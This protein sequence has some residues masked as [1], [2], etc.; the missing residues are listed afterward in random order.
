MTDDYES[1]FAFNRWADRHVLDACRTLTPEQ[2]AAEPVP[3]WSSVRSSLVHNAIVIDGW[4][5]GLTGVVGGEPLTE[6]DLP[7][8]DDIERL[9]DRAGRTFEEL[10]PRFTP[11]WLSTPLTLRR[12][13]RS[14]ALPPWVVLRHVVNHSTYHRGQVAS[15]LKRF[16][17]EPPRIDFTL[18]AMEQMPQAG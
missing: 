12:G 16:G 3:G 14:V 2:Y 11:E 8:I 13:S 4:L 15:K 18:W 10:R 17:V 1:L 6:A 9:L 7:A 5:A